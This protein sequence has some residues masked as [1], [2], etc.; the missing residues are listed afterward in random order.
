MN[1]ATKLHTLCLIF[2]LEKNN[3]QKNKNNYE[4]IIQN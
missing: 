4:E 2:A 1:F 3:Q